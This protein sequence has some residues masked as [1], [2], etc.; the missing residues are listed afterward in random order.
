MAK[1][2]EAK[3][4]GILQFSNI[5]AAFIIGAIITYVIDLTFGKKQPEI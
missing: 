1:K 4:D 5:H 3:E 2:S